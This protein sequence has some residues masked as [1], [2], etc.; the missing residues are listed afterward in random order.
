MYSTEFDEQKDEESLKAL[1][2]KSGAAGESGPSNSYWSALL[3]RTNQRL[4]DATSGKA[5][6]ISWA[7]R[8]A[9]P[10]VVAILFFFIGLHYYVPEP[11]PSQGSPLATVLL[12]L[13]EETQDSLLL[14]PS[15]RHESL[16]RQDFYEDVFELSNDQITT[17]FIETGSTGTV[18]ET[19]TDQ[20][21][22]D[23]LATLS[24]SVE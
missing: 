21:M 23:L 17:Y 15:E 3:A 12:S 13:P 24:S 2:Q 8:V 19:M 20:E 10:G 7:A 5:L 14:E 6:S 1:L 22:K 9:I 18:L 4:D 16:S 11:P